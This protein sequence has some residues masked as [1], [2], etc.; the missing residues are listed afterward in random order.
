MDNRAAKPG[1]IFYD[2]IMGNCYSN[3]MLGKAK[4]CLVGVAGV[5]HATGYARVVSVVTFFCGDDAVYHAHFAGCASV[6]SEAPVVGM[7]GQ[8]HP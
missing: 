4:L 3:V 8:L 5:A 7:V 1:G 2:V 6:G